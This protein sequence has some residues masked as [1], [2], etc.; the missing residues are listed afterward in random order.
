L[1]QLSK[2]CLRKKGLWLVKKNGPVT[3]ADFVGDL[4]ALVPN[5][6]TLLDVGANVGQS[7]EFFASVWPKVRI[8]SVEPDPVN[9]QKIQKLNHSNMAGLINVGLGA[10]DSQLELQQFDMHSL[11]SFLGP[12]EAADSP[13]KYQK[14]GA[15]ITVRVAQPTSDYL[16]SAFG[17]AHMDVIKIDTQGYELQILNGFD[18]EFLSRTRVLILEANFDSLYENQT[19]ISDLHEF[20]SRQGFSYVSQYEITR[21]TCG[22]I[23]WCTCV[24]VNRQLQ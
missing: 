9:Y 6:S 2:P 4:Q 12:S 21:N 5:P 11:N 24:Y 8:Y 20:C 10:V 1:T 16:L 14:R 17:T 15:P 7:I 18:I 22:G 23:S 19:S 3:G 13:L